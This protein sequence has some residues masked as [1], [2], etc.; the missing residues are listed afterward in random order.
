MSMIT[1]H[2]IAGYT[3]ER[4][5]WNLAIKLAEARTDI[6]KLKASDIRIENDKFVI[7]A[8]SAN[9]DEKANV[10]TIG[11]LL[12]YA[13]MGIEVFEG[14]DVNRQKADT[15]VPRISSSH[16]GAQLSE[17]VYRC[18]NHDSALRPSLGEIVQIAKSSLAISPV[19]QKR[20][21]TTSGHSYTQSLVK[22]WPEE[23]V[24]VIIFM[25]SFVSPQSILAQ[26][27]DVELCAIVDRC[28]RLRNADNTKLVIPEFEDDMK[29]TLLDEIA[30]DRNGE[31]TVNDPVDM[32]GINDI[33]ARI[34]KYQDGVVNVGGRFRNGQD[35]RYKYSLIE[36]TVKAG[37]SVSYDI[38]KRL[39]TQT[40]AVIPYDPNASYS[41]DISQAGV[42]LGESI[43]SDGVSYITTSKK[44]TLADIFTIR[45]DNRSGRNMAFVIVNYNSRN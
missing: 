8:G 2:D 44:M 19:R 39:G 45:I 20:L 42:S 4:N 30:I 9:F 26:T 23:I 15:A 31:C 14:G 21:T 12:F 1:L 28:V 6:T 22:F 24:G 25:I 37:T 3:T 17:L 18:L 41:V 11:A 29:W 32:F 40:F 33:G 16:A 36:V 34:I 27:D 35:P 5:V 43:S 13:V 38:C 7:C 10:W